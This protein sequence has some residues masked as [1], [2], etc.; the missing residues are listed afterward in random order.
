MAVVLPVDGSDDGPVPKA[1]RL[2]KKQPCPS[3]APPQRVPAPVGSLWRDFTLEGWLN[4]TQRK[5]YT[6]VYSKFRYLLSIRV[7]FPFPEEG[8]VNKRLWLF[9]H[10]SYPQLTTSQRRA[11]I[12]HFVAH[13]GA[14]LT[15]QRHWE[16][17]YAPKQTEKVHY[18]SLLL[19]YVG[20]WG[21]LDTD[22]Q[23]CKRMTVE[24]L[25]C[26]V[27]KLPEA[28]VLSDHFL[29]FADSLSKQCQAEGY[30]ASVELC[31]K[32]WKAEGKVKLH[33]HIYLR[34]RTKR[35]GCVGYLNVINREQLHFEGL[36]PHIS[37]NFLG[38]PMSSS[39][40]W[41][42][43]YYVNCPK[44]GHCFVGGTYV[45]NEDFPVSPSWILNMLEC[46]KFSYEIARSEIVR[47]V[48][49][50][51]SRLATLD[52]WH[53]AKQMVDMEERVYA[54][55]TALRDTLRPFPKHGIVEQWLAEAQAPLQAR[56]KFLIL[57]GPS[58]TGKTE[59]VRCLFAVGR[60]LELNLAGVNVVCLQSFQ[61]QKPDCL[62]WDEASPALVA[63]NRK[64]F[65]HPACMV[66]TGHSPTGQYV[67]HVFLNDCVSIICSNSW[68]AEL[69]KLDE[70]SRDWV[71][72]NSV[73]YVITQPMW[74]EPIPDVD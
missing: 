54:V 14:P 3:I 26:V 6:Y 69:T 29:A 58:R 7:D 5:Q 67:L 31:P 20:T 55:Q 28:I 39:K 42:G 57:E 72:A 49:G 53:K 44:L 47:C 70:E 36:E 22:G 50:C 68:S 48:K 15:I 8:N 73:L 64:L 60:V 38:L 21:V 16:Q 30:V 27:R 61:H 25:C 63:R 2:S 71:V 13:S 17:N 51:D 45:R 24:D 19:T 65:Q 62:L 35:N 4:K 66:D 11:L 10:T 18:G 23:F 59:Y 52:A 32:T 74:E 46:G 33:G 41:L 40:S 37:A 34:A 1:R 43:A 12:A 56:K 9:G